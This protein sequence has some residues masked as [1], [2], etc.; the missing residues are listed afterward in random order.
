MGGCCS[1]CEKARDAFKERFQER[2]VLPTELTWD[3]PD[4]I[5]Y[6]TPLSSTQLCATIGDAQGRM[7]YNPPIGTIL[8]AGIHTL[9]VTFTFDSSIPSVSCEVSL[10]VER[11]YPQLTWRPAQVYVGSRLSEEAHLNASAPI[12]AD[13]S[14]LEGEFVYWSV[15]S[16]TTVSFDDDFEKVRS[17]LLFGALG[18]DNADIIMVD[19]DYDDADDEKEDEG[20]TN[21]K[22]R[23]AT[24]SALLNDSSF[25]SRASVA[26]MGSTIS[27]MERQTFQVTGP[28]LSP[29]NITVTSLGELE[30]GVLFKPTD[31]NYGRAFLQ[32]KL[33]VMPL[34][35]VAFM[36]DIVD[37]RLTLSW[38]TSL[39]AS[40]T[41]TLMHP[42]SNLFSYSYS[43][44]YSCSH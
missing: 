39:A 36:Q 37:V 16:I 23:K 33:V 2:P 17:D 11:G 24:S 10:K 32:R 22:Q 26:S 40:T 41:D 25:M 13:G 12:K 27:L 43:C 30:I 5:T 8:P 6:P 9:S 35:S 7:T 3:T 21:E 4:T 19:D 34:P 20:P 38:R 15:E 44:S 29:G 1:I 14:P 28:D 42:S 18:C 31:A